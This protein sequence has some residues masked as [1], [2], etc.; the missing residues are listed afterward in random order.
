M[1]WAAFVLESA[2]E[3]ERE[4]PYGSKSAT[5]VVVV[6]QPQRL[7]VSAPVESPDVKKGRERALDRFWREILHAS[8]APT[9]L[10]R[11]GPAA[12]AAFLPAARAGGFA[13]AAFCSDEGR[14]ASGRCFDF[15][16]V[17]SSTLSFLS[18]SLLFSL[19]SLLS[20]SQRCTHARVRCTPPACTLCTL[21]AAHCPQLLLPPSA[22]HP[23][24]SR[25][26]C[27]QA[28]RTIAAGAAVHHLLRAVDDGRRA[29]RERA[30]VRAPLWHEV[31]H[32]LAVGPRGQL[33]AVQGQGEEERG[34]AHLPAKGTR[35]ATPAA[36]A[37]C[38][39]A[40]GRAAAMD[41]RLTPG[42]LAPSTGL[43]GD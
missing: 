37:A 30:Q 36:Q 8:L 40:E 31:R 1:Q 20:V 7:R 10:C 32:A 3:R 39:S 16:A 41:T 15:L 38:R 27:R 35:G 22:V 4:E 25:C 28:H 12:P 5:A 18:L 19:L 23:L 13:A 6:V 21:C 29:P 26:R 17:T 9:L 33:P 43:C 42:L 34:P 24:C 11:A 14:R 2:A